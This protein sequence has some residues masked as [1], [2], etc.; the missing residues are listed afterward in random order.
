LSIQI[1]TSAYQDEFRSF[2]AEEQRGAVPDRP[3]VFYGSSSIRL[4]STLARD[5]AGLPVI[6]RG[7]GGST[8]EECAALVDQFVARVKP[9]AIVLYAGDNDLDQ[10]ASPEAVL[11]RFEQFAGAVRMRLGWTPI[12]F[13]SIKP[14]P[15]RFW[16]AAKIGKANALIAQAI[17]QRWR[18]AQFVDIFDPMLDGSGG[19]RPEL[20]TEDGLH[21]N[22]AGYALWSGAIRKALGE[23]GLHGESRVP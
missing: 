3:I 15:A 17:S 5:F 2:A 10:G 12:V 9:R 1:F 20:F 14:S 22:A 6:N 11:T 21:M 13:V 18:E 7:F 16:N 23:L 19:P 8:L 4:W